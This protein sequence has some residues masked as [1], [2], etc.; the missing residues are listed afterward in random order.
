[1]Y[2]KTK[3]GFCLKTLF[4]SKS[5]A[6]FKKLSVIKIQNKIRISHIYLRE[7]LKT[8]HLL[9]LIVPKPDVANHIYGHYHQT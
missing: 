6:M 3:S 7:C 5:N 2:Q 9:T 8:G 1:M 4:H